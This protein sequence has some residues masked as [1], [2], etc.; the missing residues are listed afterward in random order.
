MPA[1]NKVYTVIGLYC[2]NSQP[3][4]VYVTAKSAVTAAIAAVKK[5]ENGPDKCDTDNL[6]VVEVFFG[7]VHGILGNDSTLSLERLEELK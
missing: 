3:W 7:K 6:V 4:M 1:K 5:L 2:D